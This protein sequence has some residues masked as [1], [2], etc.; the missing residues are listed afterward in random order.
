MARTKPHL[1]SP[2]KEA[3]R[4]H[5]IQPCIVQLMQLFKCKLCP[6]MFAENEDQAEHV[7]SDHAEF[8]CLGMN[9]CGNEMCSRLFQTKE[10]RDAHHI[11]GFAPYQEGPHLRSAS[12]QLRNALSK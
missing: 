12:C 3:I 1:Q 9:G 5:K 2:I 6:R 10:Q 7:N 11:M 4:K 8:A